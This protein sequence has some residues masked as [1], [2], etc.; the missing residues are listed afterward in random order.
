MPILVSPFLNT[1]RLSNLDTQSFDASAHVAALVSAA[2]RC[3]V[4]GGG[5]AEVNK[6]DILAPLFLAAETSV[7]NLY[8]SA[9]AR[10]LIPGASIRDGVSAREA[11]AKKLASIVSRVRV[12]TGVPF[13]PLKKT[14]QTTGTAVIATDGLGLAAAALKEATKDD[15]KAL[16]AAARA[17]VERLRESLAGLAGDAEELSKAVDTHGQLATSAGAGK[18]LASA[19]ANREKGDIKAVLLAVG[20]LCTVAFLIV[21]RRVLWTFLGIRIPW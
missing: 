7:S 9:R 10:A 2:E 16:L 4:S 15:E 21:L 1:L 19:L 12:E 14:K 18:E 11:E 3:V 8:L 5:P 17:G 20:I 6:S 13:I